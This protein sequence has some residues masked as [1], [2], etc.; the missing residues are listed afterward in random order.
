MATGRV[1]ME[2]MVPV[3]KA[4]AENTRSPFEFFREGHDACR[5]GHGHGDD[6]S[7]QDVGGI[8]EHAREFEG[9]DEQVGEGGPRG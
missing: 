8:G 5:G 6:G 9:Q 3:E 1:M 7:E 4:A 2:R